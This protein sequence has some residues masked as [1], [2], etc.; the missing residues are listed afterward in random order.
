MEMTRSNRKFRGR[1]AGRRNGLPLVFPALPAAELNFQ[2]FSLTPR[3]IGLHFRSFAGNSRDFPG[4]KVQDTSRRKL[5]AKQKLPSSETDAQ[6]RSGNVDK[7]ICNAR[8]PTYYLSRLSRVSMIKKVFRRLAKF[9]GFSRNRLVRPGRRH[10]NFIET[11]RSRF[12]Q[13]I[14]F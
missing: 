9:T 14:E 8:G 1:S 5:P 6:S 12:Q 7:K 4:E 10:P 2:E 3:E 13:E 11:S